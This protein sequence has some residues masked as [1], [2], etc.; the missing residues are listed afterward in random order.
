MKA[1]PRIS[2]ILGHYVVSIWRWAG[3]RIV[4]RSC[5]QAIVGATSLW[6]HRDNSKAALVSLAVAI[7]IMTEVGA[8]TVPLDGPLPVRE[9]AAGIFVHFGVNALMTSENEG[10]IANIGF[11]IGDDAVAVIDTGGSAREG[12]RL[13]AAIRNVTAK[14]ICYV[15]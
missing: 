1:V 11:V 10:A 7:L 3:A 15:I 9:V 2:H 13:L 5:G 8:G 6:P 14:P 12:R 4:A